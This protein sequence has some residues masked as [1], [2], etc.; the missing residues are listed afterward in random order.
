[1]AGN[2]TV[3]VGTVGEGM[4]RSTD[5]GESWKMV[6]IGNG[7][8][9]EA[10]VR[11][12]VSNSQ[13]RETV[14]AGTDK[15]IY[16]SDDAGG[17]W[18][19]LESPL[20]DYVT[21]SLAI[22]PQEP[23]VMFAG[24]G[25]P[26]LPTLF[27]STDSGE[28]WGRRPVQMAEKCPN[29]SV[30]RVTAIVVDP[31]DRRNVWAGVE[32]DGVRRSTDG[33]ETWTTING[34][35]PNPDIH[36]M[37]VAPGSPSRIFVVASDEVYITGDNGE[38][39]SS[40][41]VP[42]KFPWGYPRGIKVRPDKPEEVYLTIGD[43]FLGTIGAVMRSRDA[44]ASWEELSLPVRPNSAMWVVEVAPSQGP[45]VF[46]GSVFGYLYRSEDGG[47]TWEKLWREFPEIGSIL[48]IPS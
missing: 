31:V 20:D 12:L 11:T 26:S 39:W 9:S 7:V 34:A 22:D 36:N 27:R 16:R 28:T 42:E 38:T 32:V 19:H 15:G 1:M 13:Q 17:S 5:G 18:R 4:F 46:A 25:T 14:Y 23:R 8:H 40:V 48:C 47:D 43:T 24:T 44:G 3:I 10:L 35:I 21:W 41:G 29:V 33:G 37:A 30:P 2:L 6:H 45:T